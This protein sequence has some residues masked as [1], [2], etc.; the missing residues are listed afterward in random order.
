MSFKTSLKTV[1]VTLGVTA[2]IASCTLRQTPPG[3]Q[4]LNV[5]EASLSCMD[6]LSASIDKYLQ[7]HSSDQDVNDI[8][9]CTSKA[10]T[11]FTQRVRGQ[12]PGQYSADELRGFLEKYYV[13]KINLTDDLMKSSGII[14]TLI[15]GGKTDQ[16]SLAE[17]AKIQDAF[18][19]L[20]TVTLSLRPFMPISTTGMQG[21]V[22][23]DVSESDMNA[24]TTAL[25]AAA[26]Q[27]GTLFDLIG[28]AYT[29]DQFVD[30]LNAIEGAMPVGTDAGLIQSIESIRGRLPLGQA[31]KAMLISPSK[32]SI[33]TGSD[34]KAIWSNTARWTSLA[35]KAAWLLDPDRNGDPSI[36]NPLFPTETLIQGKNLALIN[37]IFGEFVQLLDSSMLSRPAN[38][39]MIAF[40]ELN[41]LVDMF[42]DSDLPINKTSIESIFAPLIKR[43]IAGADFGSDG[44]AAPGFTPG[45]LQHL[46]NEFTDWYEG[47]RVLQELYSRLGNEDNTLDDLFNSS[48]AVTFWQEVQSMTPPWNTASAA[49][50][51]RLTV[52]LKDPKILP[53]FYLNTPYEISFP[54][55]LKRQA[56]T[57][58]D[59]SMKNWLQELSIM[60]IQGYVE[61]DSGEDKSQPP[62][63]SVW[64]KSPGVNFN[65]F[66]TFYNDLQPFGTALKLFDPDDKNSAKNRFRE[67]D[68]FTNSSNGDGSMNVSEA[69]TYLSFDFSDFTKAGR[70]HSDLA[71][72]CP[73]IP[74]GDKYGQALIEPTCYRKVF[75]QNISQY[76]SPIVAGANFL[77]G[78]QGADKSQYE[79]L[80]EVAAR[81]VGYQEYIWMN[82]DDTQGFVGIL[83]YIESMFGRYDT[84][85]DGTIDWKEA[86]AAFPVVKN[87]LQQYAATSGTNLSDGLA[88]VVFTFMLDK[89]KVPDTVCHPLKTDVELVSWIAERAL[90]FLGHYKANRLRLAQ[91]FGAIG[92]QNGA[93]SSCGPAPSPSPYPTPAPSTVVMPSPTPSSIPSPAAT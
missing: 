12:V 80:L 69:V 4:P 89:G 74:G 17:I 49:A 22:W 13:H 46:T 9:D 88:N 21:K 55:D 27:V 36:V 64:Q 33:S 62:K 8:W 40:S 19:T 61:Y 79:Y 93:T 57:F 5:N 6:S 65:E 66:T 76:L 11:T 10:L 35:V 7:G 16:V 45:V 58:H 14:K 41:A 20:R 83:Q 18:E 28:N 71:S 30:L 47:Q 3:G 25:D 34:W 67:L 81:K 77:N 60:M 42:K 43:L 87:A 56:F 1:A 92:S 82:S 68:T 24:L 85:R 86:D 23:K 52:L 39:Q 63:R 75:F 29:F 26:L 48:T 32:E 38:Q 37:N 78:L 90:P 59:V 72:R 70:I 53:M 2:F 84:D 15:V 73:S 51:N 31:I 91:I 50:A 54:M 44:R